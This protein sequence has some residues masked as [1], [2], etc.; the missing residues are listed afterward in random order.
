MAIHLSVMVIIWIAAMWAIAFATEGGRALLTFRTETPPHL[1]LA[2]L[3]I[4]NPSSGR[5]QLTRRPTLQF[6]G[7]RL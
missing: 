3:V 5:A 4:V 7:S 2:R 1:G 6:I